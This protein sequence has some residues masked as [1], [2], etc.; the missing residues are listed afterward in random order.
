MFCSPP[1]DMIIDRDNVH[2]YPDMIS[3]SGLLCEGGH[4]L[5]RAD[6]AVG[7]IPVFSLPRSEPLPH[8]SSQA[9]PPSVP[10]LYSDEVSNPPW[11]PEQHGLFVPGGERRQKQ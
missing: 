9:P 6:S 5:K 3:G 2:T 1:I 10:T 4:N 11:V 8:I 7:I